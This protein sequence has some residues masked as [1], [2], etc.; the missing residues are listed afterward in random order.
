MAEIL[1]QLPREERVNAILENTKT[2]LKGHFLSTSGLHLDTY[3]DKRRL[4]PNTDETSEICGMFA[5]EFKDMDIEVVVAPATGGVILGFETARKLKEI[6]GKKVLDCFLEKKDSGGFGF[7]GG[8][9]KLI[10][11]KNVLIL[12]DILT[13][14]RSIEETNNAVK[15]AGGNI[16]GIGV[17][18]DRRDTE[19]ELKISGVKKVIALTRKKDLR[20]YRPEDCP[21]CK[22]DRPMDKPED[23]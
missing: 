3:I 9:E 8:Y 13:T 1:K 11:G 2:I 19:E 18:C 10:R 15:N 14:G 20:S 12:D 22:N 4:F 21:M 17:I 16:I 23:K 7:K 6:T 5:D